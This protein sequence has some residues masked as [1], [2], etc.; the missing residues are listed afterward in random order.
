MCPL[1]VFLTVHTR[2]RSDEDKTLSKQLF[3]Q[4]ALLRYTHWA[5]QSHDKT[6]RKF[7]VES[8]ASSLNEFLT[9]RIGT[10]K[11]SDSFSIA[12]LSLWQRVPMPIRIAIV[13]TYLI[14]VGHCRCVSFF[15]CYR[16]SFTIFCSS[17][18]IP[19][20]KCIDSRFP[21]TI[22]FIAQTFSIHL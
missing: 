7:I 2:S 6:F 14:L 1:S 8:R 13:L 10:P 4:N 19:I 22:S 21:C 12:S 5:S 16:T 15:A 9:L 3:H 17:H 20:T 18:S 11:T